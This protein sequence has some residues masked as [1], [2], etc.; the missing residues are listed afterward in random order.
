MPHRHPALFAVAAQDGVAQERLA[1]A[2]GET[3]MTIRGMK[4]QSLLFLR[5]DEHVNIDIATAGVV[6]ERDAARTARGFVQP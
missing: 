5:V 6:V 1:V 4:D 3:Y 2:V